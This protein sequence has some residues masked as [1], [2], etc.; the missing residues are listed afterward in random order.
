MR[1]P[2][3]STVIEIFNKEPTMATMNFSISDD[4]KDRF[5]EAIC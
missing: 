5:N 4:V 2:C 3:P 1:K